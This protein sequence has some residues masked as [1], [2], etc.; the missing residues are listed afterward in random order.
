MNYRMDWVA[1]ILRVCGGSG[2]ILACGVA[3]QAQTVPELLPRAEFI[4]HIQRL[5]GDIEPQG[6]LYVPESF[7]YS[8]TRIQDGHSVSVTG[9][10][11]I[12][13]L[14]PPALN[15]PLM[16][17]RG[18]SVNGGAP[19]VNHANESIRATTEVNFYFRVRAAATI[20]EIPII[21]PLQ[22]AVDMSIDSGNAGSSFVQWEAMINPQIN[23]FR[24]S[25]S[26]SATHI[27]NTSFGTAPISLTGTTNLTLNA[28]NYNWTGEYY[29]VHLEL[30]GSASRYATAGDMRLN[31]SAVFDALLDPLPYVDPTFAATNPVEFS[32]SENLFSGTAAADAPEPGTLVLLLPPVLFLSGAIG[33]KARIFPRLRDRG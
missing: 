13:S 27:V 14:P 19:E 15:G 5:P 8:G 9:Y 24:G 3:G 33:R 20:R 7:I 26:T 12:D 2:L 30:T 17:V 11:G 21:L 10:A 28:S 22:W 6:A 4:E 1:R 31:S 29:R 25:A 32:F 18:S 23:P 16:R